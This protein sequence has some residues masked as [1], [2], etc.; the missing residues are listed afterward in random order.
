MGA[1]SFVNRGKGQSMRDAY[2][3]LCDD[4]KEEYG[5]QQGYNGTISTTS[6]FRD[7]TD[8]FKRSKK[9]LNSFIDENIDKA[10]KWGS[11]LAICIDQPKSNTN[12]VK[13]KVNHIVT[14]GTKK[15]VL[16]F[17]VESRNSGTIGSKRTKGEAVAMA[18]K[19][20]EQTQER[21]YINMEKRLEGVSSRVAEVEYKQSTTEKEGSY[22][23]FG[24]AA[25]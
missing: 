14:K 8:E 23:F 22:V 19:H 25:E 3:R 16:Y 6:G 18:R 7:V 9:D 10:E 21:T 20:T 24:W 17:V 2:K 11:C 5:H 15:W 4:A 1:S 13:S 12:K